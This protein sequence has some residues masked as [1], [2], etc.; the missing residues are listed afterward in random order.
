LYDPWEAAC[1]CRRSRRACFLAWDRIEC[2]A[3][4]FLFAR[5]PVPSSVMNLMGQSVNTGKLA[6][7]A[8]EKRNVLSLEKSES[9]MI[10]LHQV[11]PLYGSALTLHNGW[12]SVEW[13]TAPPPTLN[14]SDVGSSSPREVVFVG[15]IP[16]Q[17]CRRH[18]AMDSWPPWTHF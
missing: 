12:D 18:H 14:G 16:I 9:I 13:I 3:A 5:F 6:E 8:N 10:G 17:S 1:R 15:S 7:C 2:I 4:E 11:R